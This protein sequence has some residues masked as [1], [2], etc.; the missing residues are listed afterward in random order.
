MAS[1]RANPEK[2]ARVTNKLFD[3][4]RRFRL[5]VEGV[6][7]YAIYM[8]DPSGI[9]INWNAGAERIKGYR[10][11]EI[12]GQH[13]SK[14]YTPEDRIL[15]LPARALEV[16]RREGKF[17]A[18]GWRVRK[19]G[20]RFFASVVIDPIYDAG[21]LIG[22]AKITRDITERQS[23]QKAL[24]DAQ[25]Q[26]KLLVS[27]VTDYALY[28]LDPEGNV[29][30]WNA[31]GQRIKGYAPEE[32][33]GQNFSRFYTP[34]D[35]AAGRP[36][37]ALSIARK[38]G[39]Y[40]EEG[41][42]VRKDGSFFWANVIIDPIRDDNGRLIGYAKITRDIT[43]RRQ[44]QL[45]LAKVQKQLAESQK[46]DA[47]GQ[48]T[49]GVAH[50]FNNLLMI[51]SGHIQTL[52][53]FA[54]KDSRAA[55]AAQAIEH[56]TQ[57]GAALTRQLLTFSRRQRVNPQTVSLPQKIESIREV[58]DS[59]IGGMVQLTIDIPQD[60]W[61][62]N[63]DIGEFEVALINLAV[64]ARDAMPD[65]GTVAIRT[66]NVRLGEDESVPPGDYV[67]IIVKDTGVGI[68]PD[69]IAKVFDPFFTT[70]DVGKGTG[71]GLSQVYGFAH[72]AGGT[73]KIDSELGKG[74]TLTIYLP[75]ELSDPGQDNETPGDQKKYIGTIL[76]VEDN[77]DV[78]SASTGLLEQL[79]YSV[80]WALNT[81]VALKEIERN[82]IDL[83]FSDIVM[84]GR[85][86]GLGLARVIQQ[87]HPGLPI[88]LATGYSEALRTAQS[89][90]KVLQKPY[91]MHELS[92]A[93]IEL[94][95]G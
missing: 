84:P 44:A 77:P 91:E 69:I 71:L 9:I 11:D 25:Q 88:L 78:A 68:P 59:G 33:I 50:D 60:A 1:K 40:E 16:A 27:N 29:S 41:L 56:A 24:H 76:L 21:T 65:G 43:E 13:F 35:Q 57:R 2:S 49:G 26:F 34:A 22:F 39:R 81:D 8:L 64:N 15:G 10:A 28:L 58:L 19:D 32:I 18:E 86:D 62:V 63:V 37:R 75:R 74:T 70:K 14:F 72:Q 4:E 20:T 47:L 83:V 5:L 46:M 45:S 85:L 94:T 7:D 79:G 61:P 80:R 52:K 90:F 95:R 87:K 3:S 23:A 17:E 42:R 67:A 12:V 53:K 30:S 93:I 6:I 92:R 31:G 38:D 89:D 51:V 55:M 36:A 82:G 66:E 48:L 73:V 54:A